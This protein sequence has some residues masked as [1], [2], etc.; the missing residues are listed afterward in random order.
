MA[1]SRLGL[2]VLKQRYRSWFG[3]CIFGKLLIKRTFAVH[4]YLYMEYLI[5]VE[6][7]MGLQTT[8]RY[9]DHVQEETLQ[10]IY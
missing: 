9:L 7:S 6:V 3:F 2:C 10:R 5:L 1:G 4:S 8:C